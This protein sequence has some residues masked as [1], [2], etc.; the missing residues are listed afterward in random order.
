LKKNKKKLRLKK[1]LSKKKS[2]ER[3]SLPVEP[4]M[5]DIAVSWIVKSNLEMSINLR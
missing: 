2:V 5:V 3:K 1:M 4:F